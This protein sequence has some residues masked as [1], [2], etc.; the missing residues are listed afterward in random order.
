MWNLVEHVA[1]HNKVDPA[2]LV[3]FALSR[4]ARYGI[5]VE[6]GDAKVSNWH[7]EDLVSDFRKFKEQT[8]PFT[9]EQLDQF[10]QIANG[11]LSSGDLSDVD[12]QAIFDHFSNSGEMPYG[13][14]K[15]RTGDP[16]SWID[17]HISS[18]LQ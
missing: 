3:D 18:V 9:Q 6:S 13:V 4:D 15:A 1:K 10:Q 7:S 17:D 16:Y 11:E 14:A 8:M 2:E 5:S 12:F